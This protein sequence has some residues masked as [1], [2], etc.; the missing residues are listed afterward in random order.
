MLVTALWISDIYGDLMKKLLTFCVTFSLIALFCVGCTDQTPSEIMKIEMNEVDNISPLVA[1]DDSIVYFVYEGGDIVIKRHYYVS[2]KT[3]ELGR[4]EKCSVF[5]KDRAIYDGIVYFHCHSYSELNLDEFMETGEYPPKF[6][7]YIYT[8]D[9]NTNK[10]KQAFLMKY[11]SV[12]H[13]SDWLEKDMIV[14]AIP[15][16][17]ESSDD[18]SISY[19][20]IAIF[21]IKKKEF[22]KQTEMFEWDTAENKGPYVYD[23]SASDGLI[24]ALMVD[25]FR[26]KSQTSWIDVYDK[27]LKIV[28]K[29][30]ID[31]NDVLNTG[32]RKFEVFD[33]KVALTNISS[34]TY[35][36]AI[37][38]DM[39]EKIY[40]D[41]V[42]ILTSWDKAKGYPIAYNPNELILL[43]SNDNLI[44]RIK[45]IEEKS[46]RLNGI[47]PSSENYFI[48]TYKTVDNKEVYEYWVVP[49]ELTADFKP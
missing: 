9:T 38:G 49:K 33:S 28:Q 41:D 24:Y 48:C 22:V 30:E 18:G 45:L 5:I 8:I 25:S 43:D 15:G 19:S 31:F 35:Y 23:V 36:G 1:L 39:V 7:N 40:S 32:S 17:E 13:Q 29:I 34:K 14:M 47:Y 3:L 26:S 42:T 2:G 6:T 12:F 27:N 46:K 4:I 37:E 10:L 11:D 21:D 20:S 44:D 16:D